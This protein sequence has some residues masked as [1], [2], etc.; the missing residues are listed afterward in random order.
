MT[1]W[2]IGTLTLWYDLRM[3]ISSP[4][5]FAHS[6]SFCS[7]AEQVLRTLA[8][9][10][11]DQFRL[12]R[13]DLKN[14]AAKPPGAFRETSQFTTMAGHAVMLREVEGSTLAIFWIYSQ[15]T[16]LTIVVLMIVEPVFGGDSPNVRRKN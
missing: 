1:R 4:S 10:N 2:H 15:T 11:Q 8:E 5:V 13:S 6:L 7:P 16:P 3:E 14:L 12:V 9:E